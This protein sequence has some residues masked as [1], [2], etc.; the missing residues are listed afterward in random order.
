MQR[1]E[2]ISL[3]K[4]YRHLF[5]EGYIFGFVARDEADEW[6]DL[7]LILVCETELSFPER[8]KA[9]LRLIVEANR[10]DVLVYT[11][12]EFQRLMRKE[13][14]VSVVVKEAIRI[15]GKQE[16]GRTDCRMP[17]PLKYTQSVRQKKQ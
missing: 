8:G 13:G 11:P 4:K 12:I 15:E 16:R 14:F 3:V 17:L 2:A 6:S 5:I 7:D 10:A 9:F 1:R